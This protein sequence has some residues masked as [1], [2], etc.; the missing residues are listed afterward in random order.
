MTVITR[1]TWTD[2]EI[3]CGHTLSISSQSQYVLLMMGREAQLSN[4]VHSRLSYICMYCVP[5]RWRWNV[6]VI[7]ANNN[8]VRDKWSSNRRYNG[9]IVKMIYWTSLIPYPGRLVCKNFLRH[10]STFNEVLRNRT[11]FPRNL[12][13]FS[14]VWTVTLHTWRSVKDH[15]KLSNLSGNWHST[16][17]I[18]PG[19]KLYIW[20]VHSYGC[21]KLSLIRT[22][23]H[24]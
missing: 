5:L 22:G 3:R 20:P 6:I 18:P 23:I 4:R 17:W 14:S 1:R 12:L 10:P 13:S 21:I 11:V 2:T 15:V 19:R 7:P 24:I 8:T 9:C 16:L